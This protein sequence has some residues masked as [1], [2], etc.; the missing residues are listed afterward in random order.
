MQSHLFGKRFLNRKL[1]I[2]DVGARGGIKEIFPKFIDSIRFQELLLHK[3]NLEFFG[4]E[5][6]ITASKALLTG[7]AYNEVYNYALYNNESTQTLYMTNDGGA[8]ASL[9]EPDLELIKQYHLI[10]ENLRFFEIVDQILVQTTFLD[11]IFDT[12]TGFDFIKIDVQGVEYE[13]IEGG[14]NTLENTIGIILEAQDIPFY[15][16]Q[17]LLLD[18]EIILQDYGFQVLE[19]KAKP[20]LPQEYDLAFIKRQELLNSRE[21]IICFAIF[22]FIFWKDHCI[23]D[24][25]RDRASKFFS[26]NEI[27]QLNEML[28]QSSFQDRLKDYIK[29]LTQ[30]LLR[31][32]H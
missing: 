24:I 25:S 9:L 28:Y 20:Q 22:C 23:K 26:K 19:K 7:G 30:K 6:D 32:K 17:K 18:I 12:H 8:R 29:Q 5:P 13:I 4:I 2:L 27:Y 21:D 14:K 31:K 11:K 3:D 10:P 15:K 16:E 1:R